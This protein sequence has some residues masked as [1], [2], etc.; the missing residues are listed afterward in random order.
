MAATRG[1]HW[2]LDVKGKRIDWSGR[3][4]ARLGWITLAAEF[5]PSLAGWPWVPGTFGWVEPTSWA[6]LALRALDGS[7]PDEESRSRTDEAT[8]FLIDRACVAGGWNFGTSRV[9][10]K[11]LWPYPDT[12]AIAL[13]AMAGRAGHPAIAAGV[14]ALEGMLAGPSSR[15]ALALGALALQTHG[16]DVGSL[17]GRLHEAW[18]AGI[19]D[20]VP[21]TRTRALTLLALSGTRVPI[22]GRNGEES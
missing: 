20:F 3:I 2:I 17:R 10:G 9:L 16:Q 8:A 4:L 5:D 12:T 6:V 11:D 18:T 13:L 21:T 14:A 7:I 1:G 15:L 22:S 19:E